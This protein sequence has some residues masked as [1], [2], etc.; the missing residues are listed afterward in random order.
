MSERSERAV[1]NHKTGCNCS[2]SVACAYCDL[3]GLDETLARRIME[4]YGLGM[5][6]ME[7]TCGALSGAVAIASLHL[8]NTLPDG[9]AKK[10]QIYAACGQMLRAFQ[11]KN[12]SVRCKDLKGVT[13]GTVLRS[14]DGCIQDAA[15]LLDTVILAPAGEGEE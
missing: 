15:E 14:C 13:G 1:A 3:V 11:E 12:G 7:G 2:Q 4:G 6:C 9:P 8:G 5:G 10:K